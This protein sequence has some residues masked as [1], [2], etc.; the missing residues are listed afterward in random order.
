MISLINKAL[1]EL[2]LACDRRTSAFDVRFVHLDGD[3]ST[4]SGRVLK[5]AQ[6]EELHRH[7]PDLKLD[8]SAIRI[9]D[10][11]D[12]P[13]RFVATHLTGLYDGPTF[14]MPLASE[15]TYGTDLE[16]LEEK[17]RW[18]FTRQRDG[19][20]GWVYGQYLTSDDVPAETHIVL[21]PSVEVHSEPAHASEIISRLMSGTGLRIEGLQDGWVFIRAHCSGWIPQAA[22]R[23]LS[24]LPKS[25]EARRGMLVE[26]SFRMT[27]VPYLWGGTSGN[28]IDCSGFMRLL[29]RWIGIDI[30]RDADMQAEAARPVKP[31]YQIGDLFFFRDGEGHRR[32]THVGMSLGGWRMIHSSRA[33][34]G[35][36][37]DDLE[38]NQTLMNKLMSAG[39][40][41]S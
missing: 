1:D 34:N 23:K 18:V 37:V 3:R 31:P 9:L 16:V 10:R 14:G 32:I 38:Q 25:L 15:L 35:V 17:D 4:L 21:S 11:P 40:F 6:V 22:L 30:P 41:L 20:L 29:H 26:D 5:A 2:A 13:H 19:Y 7:F 39:T 24:N 28:G 36:Y 27:G 33:R 12:L 8:T